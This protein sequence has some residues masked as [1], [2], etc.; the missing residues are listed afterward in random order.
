MEGCV[1]AYSVHR[2]DRCA[3]CRDSGRN[4]VDETLRLDG[5]GKAIACLTAVCV[6]LAVGG[7][8]CCRRGIFHHWQC[9]YLRSDCSEAFFYLRG[10]FAKEQQGKMIGRCALEAHHVREEGLDGRPFAYQ[11]DLHQRQHHVPVVW[12]PSVTEHQGRGEK[13]GR[14]GWILQ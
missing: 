1:I 13:R 4:Y 10:V 12:P 14:I 8:C 5:E 2:W 7:V 9:L 6:A 3:F 11:D